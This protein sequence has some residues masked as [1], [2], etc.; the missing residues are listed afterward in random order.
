MDL[1]SRLLY[2]LRD[3]EIP[4][5]VLFFPLHPDVPQSSKLAR[6]A[7]G[8]G[9]APGAREGPRERSH[10]G[11]PLVIQTIG[12]DVPKT[13]LSPESSLQGS[14]S[15]LNRS[16]P[17]FGSA[18]PR[19]SAL[20]PLRPGSA[21]PAGPGRVQ[22]F[23]IPAPARA[24][25]HREG[26]QQPAE[27][28][29][30]GDPRLGGGH[31]GA[32]REGGRRAPGGREARGESPRRCS[33]AR[34]A[35]V[36]RCHSSL[37]LLG[38]CQARLPGSV[39]APETGLDPG[40]AEPPLLVICQV[41]SRG[42]LGSC[43]SLPL[44][45]PGAAPSAGARESGPSPTLCRLSHA[46]RLPGGAPAPPSVRPAPASQ[47]VPGRTPHPRCL[48]IPAAGPK[49]ACRDPCPNTGAPGCQEHHCDWIRG[50]SLQL[51]VRCWACLLVNTTF[52]YSFQI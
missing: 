21:F 1:I 16:G 33:G 3:P 47:I 18:E 39:F 41:L 11:A 23:P 29:A 17:K 5:Q 24:P 8:R 32:G 35:G 19:P 45:S 15:A 2:S 51:L 46:P 12:R 30:Q 25:T 13:K 10:A 4:D 42:E 22:P 6:G 50:D 40:D 43:P 7:G 52:I 34:G 26:Q 31:R 37:S 9:R 49:S 38:L 36:P 48:R 44:R 20:C 27:G 28:S 14:F